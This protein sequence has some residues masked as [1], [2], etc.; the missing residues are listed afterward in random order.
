MKRFDIITIMPDL[1][2]GFT[3]ESLL[4]RA[5]KKKIFK[6]NV[7]NLRQ[8]TTD[9]HKTVDAKPFGGGVGMVLKVEP[10]LKAVKKIKQKNK[11]ARVILFSPRGKKFDQE[12][13]ERFAKLDQ[14]IL[15]SGRYEGVDERIAK[16]VADEVISIG[17]YV[18]LGGEVPSMAVIEAI[19][20][21]IPGVI[22]K[23]ESSRKPDHPQYTRP[24]SIE[25][26]GKKRGVPK[27]LLSGDHKK[28]KEWREKNTK[29]LR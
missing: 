19:S 23:E 1:F 5:Q 13:A 26:S 4:A 10:I 22:A 3:D 21:M 24:E 25:I 8:W 16:H 2:Q 6:I 14:I 7:H 15:I 17:D 18:L 20:R 9:K 12:M 28:I 27:V 11:K 29:K